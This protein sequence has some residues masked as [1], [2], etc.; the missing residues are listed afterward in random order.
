MAH[1]LEIDWRTFGVKTWCGWRA[2]AKEVYFD[3]N[4]NGMVLLC[5][6]GK[7]RTN[8][9]QLREISRNRRWGRGWRAG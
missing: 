8:I 2:L 3:H 6:S 7:F 1:F 9:A 5:I 4:R